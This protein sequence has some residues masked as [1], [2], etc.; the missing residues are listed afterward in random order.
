M[1]ASPQLWPLQASFKCGKCQGRKNF[2]LTSLREHPSPIPCGSIW[3]RA[4]PL[5]RRERRAC[6]RAASSEADNKS[7]SCYPL[8]SCGRSEVWWDVGKATK[9][10]CSRGKGW[11]AQRLY[12]CWQL[13]PKLGNPLHV[14]GFKTKLLP[15]RRYVVWC[16]WGLLPLPPST[17]TL[18]LDWPKRSQLKEPSWVYKQ[19]WKRKTEWH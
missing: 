5:A 9:G 15:L 6:D 13:S 19:K 18:I 3:R 16:Y 4:Y 1:S 7:R 10:L 14:F 11:K 2:T 8:R 12:K 17:A